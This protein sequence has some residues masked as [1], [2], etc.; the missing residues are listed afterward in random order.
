M[1]YRYDF[2]WI[3]YDRQRDPLALIVRLNQLN[4][5]GW[6]LVTVLDRGPARRTWAEWWRDD[7]PVRCLQ[8]VCRQ[9]IPPNEK[10]IRETED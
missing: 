9:Q 1:D 4:G 8:I 5:Q 10:P 7:E 6:E 2:V 3:Y